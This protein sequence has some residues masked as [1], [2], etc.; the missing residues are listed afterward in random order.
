MPQALLPG[1]AGYGSQPLYVTVRGTTDCNDVIQ[2]T[3]NG[4]V[5]DPSPPSLEVL[6]TGENAIEHAQSNN[7][8]I[9]I[10]H[11]TYQ[12][13]PSFSSLWRLHDDHSGLNGSSVVRIGT[14]PGGSDVQD[15][16]TTVDGS[17]RGRLW[18]EGIPHYVTVTGTNRAGVS[19]TVSSRAVVLDTSPPT[20]GQVC[21]Y[22]YNY[23]ILYW[24]H[25]TLHWDRS[26]IVNV[27]H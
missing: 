11:T 23:A 6:G 4:F 2:S 5:I 3:S 17:V 18:D 15:Q 27:H 22:V 12:T 24:T 16:T 21:V 13:T 8:G 19:S 1:L 14:Y 10:N 20:L 25:H 26:V 7:N 9:S